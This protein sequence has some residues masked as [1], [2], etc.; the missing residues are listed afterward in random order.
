MPL[1]FRLAFRNVLRQRRRSI[2]TSL[3]MIGGY[4]LCAYSY[5]LVDGSYGNII[6]IFTQD[7]TGHVEIHKGD[8]LQRARIYKT[9][10]DQQKVQQVLNAD[11]HVVSYTPRVYAPALAY[12]GDKNTPVEVVGVDPVRERETSLLAKKLTAGHWFTGKHDPDSYYPALVG[13]GVADVLKL[14][15]GS[16][17]ILI[18]QGADGSVANDIFVVQGIVGTS[19]SA[20]KLNV[21]L[22]LKAAQEFLTLQGR[23]HEYA[24]LLDNIDLAREEAARLQQQLPGL[25]VSPWQDVEQT[26]YRSMESDKQGNN[27]TLGIILFIVFIGVLNT[28]LMS[29]LER[30]REFGVLRAIGSRPLTIATLI[31]LETT[32]LAVMSIAI[33]FIIAL[34]INMFFTWHGITMPEPIELGGV[35]FTEMKGIL[36]VSVFVKPA[37]ILLAYAI[38]VSIPPAIRAARIAPTSAMRSF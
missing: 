13:R 34:P 29:V 17:L 31:S 14:K 11:P 36:S 2:L 9:I 24:I 15:L 35:A 20:E 5:S 4:I 12:A 7:R 22:P 6:K 16:Q 21:Y 30:T 8:Y 10:D 19:D 26:F 27:F 25:T 1:L 3:S 28:V 37:F 33:G 18:S 23:V 38:L 32:I